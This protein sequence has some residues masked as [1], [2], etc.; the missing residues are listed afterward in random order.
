MQLQILTY[1]V[2]VVVGLL[3][4]VVELGAPPRPASLLLDGRTAC[5]VSE[6]V[7]RCVVDLGPAPRVHLLELVRKGPAGNVVERAIRWVNRPG[8]AEAEIQ[9]QTRCEEGRDRCSVRIGWAHPERLNPKRVAVA[10]DGRR[11]APAKT[12]DVSLDVSGARGALLTVD[13]TFPDGRRAAHASVLGGR[14]RGDED[15]SVTGELVVDACGLAG[16]ADA[17]KCRVAAG[18]HV[19]TAERGEGEIVF[20]AEPAAYGALT[21]I[22]GPFHAPQRP[23]ERHALDEI[24]KNDLLA[25]GVVVPDRQ[26]SRGELPPKEA[27]LDP[28]LEILDATPLRPVRLADAVASAAFRAGIPGRR[29]LVVL[30]AAEGAEDTSALGA[31]AVRAYL[32]EI[33]VPLL[34]WR[35]RPAARPEWPEG[36]AIAD[37]AALKAALQA[38]RESLDCQAVL[39]TE[40][41]VP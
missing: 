30:I 39:W 17:I 23:P 25:A 27:V 19:R 5:T 37:L 16:P 35:M 26:L 22:L 34:V 32:D 2:G 6:A 29:R 11:V 3:P 8:A 36:R 7:P 20:V 21:G 28:I 13:M 12:R 10:L 41:A 31:A 15:V 1:P 9:T 24:L 14:I 38:A 33:R 4:V 18:G 40:P